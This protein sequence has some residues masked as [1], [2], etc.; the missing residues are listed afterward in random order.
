MEIVYR[1]EELRQYME[2]AV[3]VSPDHPVLTDRYL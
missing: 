3:K 1:E 2:N